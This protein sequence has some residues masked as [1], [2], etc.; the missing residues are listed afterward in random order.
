[1]LNSLVGGALGPSRLLASAC[2]KTFFVRFL[3]PCGAD[4]QVSPPPHRC[5]ASI[6]CFGEFTRVT[7]S[8]DLG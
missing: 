7:P 2:R 1:M 8:D 6:K 5:V 3:R 4:F